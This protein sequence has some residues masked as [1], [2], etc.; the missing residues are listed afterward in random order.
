MRYRRAWPYFVSMHN[1]TYLCTMCCDR[2]VPKSVQRSS[3]T[4][5]VKCLCLAPL[6]LA[7][8]GDM[9]LSVG[10]EIGLRIVNSDPGVMD[11]FR[12]S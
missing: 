10:L 7:L 3:T 9:T 11:R 1:I 4:H 12:P 5:L 2:D 6:N 8:Q